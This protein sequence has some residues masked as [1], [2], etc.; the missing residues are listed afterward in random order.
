MNYNKKVSNLKIVIVNRP[1]IYLS[2]NNTQKGI[3]KYH[4][5]E[6]IKD[7]DIRWINQHDKAISI[8]NGDK[9]FKILEKLYKKALKSEH[10]VF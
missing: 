6:R 3:N 7:S 8:I 1:R 9:M 4:C 10:H 2:W 5:Y